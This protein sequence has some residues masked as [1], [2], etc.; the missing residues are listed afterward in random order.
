[1]SFTLAGEAEISLPCLPSFRFSFFHLF[2]QVC[3]DC[4]QCKLSVGNNTRVCR[5]CGHHFGTSRQNS[6]LHS[7]Q[8]QS[9]Q[10]P[11][12]NSDGTPMETRKSSRRRVKHN[13]Q[14]DFDYIDKDEATHL[15][16]ALQ[17]SRT[18]DR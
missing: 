13:P 3:K 12:L 4:P 15:Q 14:K 18:T 9:Y 11:Q 6:N 7:L 16:I 2:C 8:F 5:Q 1:M 10:P 17:N